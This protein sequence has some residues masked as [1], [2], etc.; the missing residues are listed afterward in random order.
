M[1]HQITKA[2]FG[3]TFF[4]LVGLIA[5][6]V[7]AAV[8]TVTPEFSGSADELVYATRIRN[9]TIDPGGEMAIAYPSEDQQTIFVA[10]Y[11][12]FEAWSEVSSINNEL[13]TAASYVSIR[14]LGILP[15]RTY[16]I[17]HWVTDHFASDGTF[18]SSTYHVWEV[19]RDGSLY[20][21]GVTTGT[22][23]EEKIKSH[24]TEAGKALL[25]IIPVSQPDYNGYIVMWSDEN[26]IYANDWWIDWYEGDTNFQLMHGDISTGLF[27][28]SYSVSPYRTPKYGYAQIPFFI[29]S[30]SDGQLRYSKFSEGT[31]K[32]KADFTK[33]WNVQSEEGEMLTTVLGTGK[34][35]HIFFRDGDTLQWKQFASNG[36]RLD[37]ETIA[38]I[39][40]LTPEKIKAVYNPYGEGQLVVSWITGEGENASVYFRY[41]TPGTGW[42][43]V[44]LLDE[45]IATGSKPLIQMFKNGRLEIS[46]KDQT[47]TVYE[48]TYTPST[49][50]WSEA[51]SVFS[52]SS[53]VQIK[54]LANL[55]LVS[56]SGKK[57]LMYIQKN[58][59]RYLRR[60]NMGLDHQFE[61]YVLPEGFDLLQHSV[62]KRKDFTPWYFALVQDGQI[63]KS[64]IAEEN[65]LF[66]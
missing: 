30:Y 11:D 33:T 55:S 41:W 65:S 15:V 59:Q 26:K 54:Q 42:N 5:V 16:W 18:L 49:K 17:V 20:E 23:D 45:D 57:T 53:N 43:D 37:Q 66:E 38:S 7:D 46:W 34:Q 29:A 28:Q 32:V 9:S 22:W 56:G 61:D 47:N 62:V 58:N 1:L 3:L 24:A 31:N 40:D 12:S 4:I 2:L 21:S 6:P 14:Q 13:G 25:E 36:D 35:S 52:N 64:I 51:Q 60:W 48:T 50:S 63:L 27:R 44:T 39:D 19:R 8:S 10:A